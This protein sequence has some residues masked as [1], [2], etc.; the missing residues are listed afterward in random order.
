MAFNSLKALQSAVMQ[1]AT[2]TD[3]LTQSPVRVSGSFYTVFTDENGDLVRSRT[4]YP[5][6]RGERIQFS[7]KTGGMQ[8]FS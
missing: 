3:A 4:A 1:R 5:S 6:E 8:L 7:K 2:N